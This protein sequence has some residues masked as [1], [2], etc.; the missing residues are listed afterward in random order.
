MNQEAPELLAPD[1]TITMDGRDLTSVLDPRMMRLSVRECR[2]DEADTLDLVLDDSDGKL[3]IPKRGAVLSVAIGWS[4][5]A[6]V[7]KGSFTVN[8]VE[9]AGTPDTI[10]VRARSASMTKGMGERQ[11]KSWHDQSV[12]DI[13]RTIA[14]RHQLTPKVGDELGKFKIP[15]IDQTHESDMSFLT[16]LARRFDAVMTVKEGNLLFLPIGTGATMSGQEVPAI[17][18]TRQDGDRHR[19][20]VSERENYSAVRAYWHNNGEKKRHSVVVGGEDNHSVKVLPENY[21]S[22]AEAER[23]ATAEF[24]RT[25]R[26]QATFNYT[27]AI[28]QPELRPEAPV[29]LSG[30]NKPEIDDEDWLVQQV[31]HTLDDS[32][33]YTCDMELEILDDPITKR[34][35][36]NFRKGGN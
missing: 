3:E 6:L 28:G 19:F 18:L 17:A 9:H 33:G 27:M 11:E 4:G 34:H 23:A 24:E 1:Y 5:R 31:T 32:G 26:S 10:T 25:K 16:R 29:T 14:G 30:W 36:S 12:G 8:E 21:A 35:R 22:Q 2:A 15:H 20:H 7:D 13:V